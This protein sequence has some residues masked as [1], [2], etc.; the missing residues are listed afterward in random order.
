[1]KKVFIII[2]NRGEYIGIHKHKIGAEHH[3][4]QR[5]KFFKT[6]KFTI[7]EFYLKEIN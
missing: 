2:D 6:T 7:K 5:Q 1:M 3:V 4:F